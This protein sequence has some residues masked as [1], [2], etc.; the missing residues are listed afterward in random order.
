MQFSDFIIRLKNA[1]MARRRTVVLPC[2]KVNKAIGKILI[3]E[4]FLEDLKEEERENKKVLIAKIRYEQRSPMITGALII[5]KPSLRVYSKS[6]HLPKKRG[7]EISI[8][9][10]SKGIMSGDQAL[11]KGLGGEVLFKIW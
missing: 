6:I 10:T 11:E 8:V 3:N 4:L 1:S 5:S 7:T 2:S 9:S